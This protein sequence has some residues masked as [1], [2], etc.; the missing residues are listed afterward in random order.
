MYLN[1]IV[2]GQVAQTNITVDIPI[3]LAITYISTFLRSASV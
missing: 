3:V 2:N 1:F